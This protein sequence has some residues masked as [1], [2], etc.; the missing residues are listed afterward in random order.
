MN[1][2]ELQLSVV[3]LQEINNTILRNS[4]DEYEHSLGGVIRDLAMLEFLID[5]LNNI[6]EPFLQS[7]SCFTKNCN[8]SSILAGE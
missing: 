8:P 6:S 4:P 1:P 5:E 2:S 3:I 7:R